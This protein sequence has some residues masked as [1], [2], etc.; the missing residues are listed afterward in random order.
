MVLAV[1][2]LQSIPLRLLP[3][4]DR[5]GAAEVDES[6]VGKFLYPY[7]SAYGTSLFLFLNHTCMTLNCNLNLA[8]TRSRAGYW[9]HL[10]CSAAT[11]VCLLGPT[12]GAGAAGADVELKIGIVQR[13]T[14]II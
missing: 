5:S 3:C 14:Q 13:G 9:S 1:P 12:A 4:L 6:A 7:H 2:S 11:T 8:L 10:L